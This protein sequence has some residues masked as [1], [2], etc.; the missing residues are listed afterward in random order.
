MQP[1]P[2]PRLEVCIVFIKAKK[3]HYL[4]GS[5]AKLTPPALLGFST[6]QSGQRESLWQLTLTVQ[7]LGDLAEKK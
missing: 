5:D 2:D 3:K 1:E 6:V 4:L 7:S